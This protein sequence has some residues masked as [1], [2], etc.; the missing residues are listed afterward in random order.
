MDGAHCP[1]GYGGG[2]GPDLAVGR[3]WLALGAWFGRGGWFGHRGIYPCAYLW[4]VSM[5]PA[6]LYSAR[7]PIA[8]DIG[9]DRAIWRDAM[10]G[11]GGCDTRCNIVKSRHWWRAG[12][13]A[14]RYDM[15]S[16]ACRAGG[17]TK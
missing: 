4:R 17:G 14:D 9:V 11:V 12:G 13:P 10:R 2:A 5:G 7:Q 15:V 1:V 6:G 3:N 16:H 8:G